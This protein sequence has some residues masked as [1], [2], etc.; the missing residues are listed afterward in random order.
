MVG[1]FHLPSKI[2]LYFA[3]IVKPMFEQKLI[4]LAEF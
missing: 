2:A 1:V 4:R 3:M